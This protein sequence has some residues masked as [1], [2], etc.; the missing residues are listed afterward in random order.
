M[1][2]TLMEKPPEGDEWIHEVKFEGY[3]SQ[4]II[5][6]EGVR[7]F[8]RRVLDWTSKYRGLAKAAGD[9]EVESAII[10]GEKPE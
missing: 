3:R 2:P 1:L 9:L 5:D 10:A 7:I 4:I 6:D 8:T